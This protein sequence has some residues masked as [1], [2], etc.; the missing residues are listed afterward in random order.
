MDRFDPGS[1]LFLGRSGDPDSYY[2]SFGVDC[3]TALQDE[4]PGPVSGALARVDPDGLDFVHTCCL[5]RLLSAAGMAAGERVFARI[6]EFRSAD[7]GYHQRPG[8]RTS[9]A[10][11]SLLGLGAYVDHGRLPPGAERIPRG[12]RIAPLPGWWLRQ[13]LRPPARRNAADRRCG[14]RPPPVPT[15][16]PAGPPRVLPLVPRPVGR[17]PRLPGRSMPGT[18][19]RPRLP[20]MRSTASRPTTP[21][22]KRRSWTTS[23]PSGRP[24]AGSTGTGR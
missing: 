24:T 3:L 20:S 2:T 15:G 1:G 5:A 22:S 23:I 8:A 10:Y 18:P 19:P 16:S 4:V 14:D 21:R 9:T 6:E 17:V 13:R 12:G 7:G 11:A